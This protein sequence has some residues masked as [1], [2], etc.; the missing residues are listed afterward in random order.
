MFKSITAP[1]NHRLT[2]RP[3]PLWPAWRF[4][5]TSVVPEAKADSQV[6]NAVHQPHA[7]G[8]RLPVL[9][10][11]AACSSRG[12][13]HYEQSCQFDRR[14]PANEVTDGSGHR[15]SLTDA[16]LRLLDPPA[17]ARTGSSRETENRKLTKSFYV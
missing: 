3:P 6:K 13:P 2:R 4:I 9:A 5:W 1:I 16:T 17:A 11:G 7:K 15:P 14:R 10:K 12:W 8:D